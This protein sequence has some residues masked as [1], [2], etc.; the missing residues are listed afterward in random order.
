MQPVN[1]V[2]FRD[3]GFL[4]EAN[5]LFFHPRGLCL[6]V[7]FRQ[8]KHGNQYGGNWLIEEEVAGAVYPGLGDVVFSSF[9]PVDREKA[10]RVEAVR[11]EKALARMEN[12]GFDVEP[13][14]VDC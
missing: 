7:E 8:D 6:R 11:R 4:Q 1:P 5:R 12:F 9:D 13:V 3:F 2:K 10:E 14:P